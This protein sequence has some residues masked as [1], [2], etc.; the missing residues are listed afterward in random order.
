MRSVSQVRRGDPPGCDV[1]TSRLRV[2][3]AALAQAIDDAVG[4]GIEVIDDSGLKVHANAAFCR[5]VGWTRDQLVG[6]RPPFPYWPEEEIPRIRGVFQL[7]LEGRFPAEGVEVVL[8]RR[9]G[10]RFPALLLVAPLVERGEPRGWVANIV[11]LSV[12]K[13]Q[14]EALK[15]E[16]LLR[17]TQERLALAEQRWKFALEGAGQGVW[18]W[19]VPT[20]ASYYSPRYTQMLGY[21]QA[22]F[23]STLTEWSKRVHP[24]DLALIM[25][26]VQRH[27]RGELPEIEI[28]FRMRHRDGHYLWIHSRGL[29]IE[30][31][32]DGAPLRA[33]GTHADV[34]QRRRDE[35]ALRTSLEQ[36]NLATEGAHVGLWY[37][38]L[39]DG[40]LEWSPLCGQML[41]LPD[42]EEP[43]FAHFESVIHPEDRTRVVSTIGEAIA[44][45]SEFALEYR[46]CRTD[47][48]ARWLYD[49]GRVYADATGNPRGIGGILTDVTARKELE[50]KLAESET[51][52]RAL[53]AASSDAV[54]RMN[55]DWTQMEHLSGRAFLRDTHS[56]TRAWIDDYVP[57]DDQQRV[58]AAIDEAIARRAVFDLEHRVIRADGSEGWTHS[59]AV[60]IVGDDGSLREWFGMASD[61]TARRSAQERVEA[62]TRTL[63]Q[64]NAE[65]ERRAEAAQVANRAKSAFLAN[66]SHE[67]RTP[68]NG[69][70]GMAHLVRMGGLTA[71]QRGRMDKLETAARHLLQILNA[72][73]DLSKIDAGKFS[74]EQEPVSVEAI[75]AN[76]AAILEGQA[77]QKGLRLRSEVAPMPRGLVGDPTRLQQALLNFGTNAIRFTDSG[78][79]VL[80]AR[81]VD[82]DDDTVLVQF[83]VED[84][85]IGIDAE[86]LPRL[87][88]PFEQGDGSMTRKLGGTGLGLAIARRL[89][90][91]MGGQADATSTPGAGSTFWFTARLRRSAS[92]GVG[93]AQRS[94]AEIEV[95]ARFAG[96]RVL[97]AED[98]PIC[99]EVA[100]ELLQ[101]AGLAA[102][103]AHDGIEAVR[104]IDGAD[105]ALVLMDLQMPRK[106]GFEAT[107]ELRVTRGSD[108]LPIVA[109]TANA[110]GEDRLRC[111]EA[112]M[113]AF[114]AKPFTPE[115]FYC[116]LARVLGERRGSAAR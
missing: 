59:R 78:G 12:Q 29:L 49:A 32:P 105:Y 95:R 22:E 101:D 42:H 74:V 96:A 38:P 72:I 10:E 47:G 8:Q 62:Q 28:E 88:E 84:T 2:Y 30:R 51:R 94:A 93:A 44:R 69:V 50:R 20:G 27:F 86:T 116:T 13:A 16:R 7:A 4:S 99:R 79:V 35:E 108:V 36:L 46:V 9:S 45:R 48:E 87:F 18:D 89:A 67:I 81:P 91:L 54:Y 21:S 11:D 58:R 5:M 61:V 113:D 73:L 37:R 65:L 68:L 25:D 109:M 92:P 1:M 14:A 103:C 15:A 104:M 43:T 76:T 83:E 70:I 39:P 6:L 17:E 31:G 53:V 34:T 75:V 23:G 102:D 90:E 56:P 71:E 110:F 111:A 19:D 40:S 82:H 64:L 41:S 24:D 57:H 66:M 85:G 97:V 3:D 98:D 107:R 77:Q 63:A 33:I 26:T 112:G 115:D 100:V 55:A 80:R 52:Y 60:P 114:L 106:D